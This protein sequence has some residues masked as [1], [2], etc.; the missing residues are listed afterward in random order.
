MTKHHFPS[1]ATRMDGPLV[2]MHVDVCGLV[3]V[4]ARDVTSTS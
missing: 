2:F 3:N 1:K 4:Q